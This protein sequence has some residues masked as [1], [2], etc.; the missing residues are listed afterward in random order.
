MIRRSLYMCFL[1][2]GLLLACG[3]SFAAAPPAASTGKV[4]IHPFTV[5]GNQRLQ[6][7]G[8]QIADRVGNELKTAGMTVSV[9]AAPGKSV[10]N[11]RNTLLAT[12]ARAAVWGTLALQGDGFTLHARVLETDGREH[13]LEEAEDSI[14]L[15]FGSVQKLS[16]RIGEL[17][18]GRDT[19]GKVEI[20][21]NN[22]IEDDAISR[23][24]QTAP[25]AVYLQ[26]SLSDDL[27]SIY[28]MG[29][30]EDIQVAEEDG[31]GGKTVIFT[32]EEKPT[33]RQIF[34][35]G[36]R[37]YE[38]EKVLEVVTTKT[39]AILNVF[40]VKR[41]I[42]RIRDLYREKNYH[43]TEVT[44]EINPLDNNQ[45]D[46][47]FVI[48]EGEKVK[49]AEILFE[50]NE[51]YSEKELKK[52]IETSEKGWFS[53]LTGSGELKKEA[54]QQDAA[55]MTAFYHN[56]GFAEA[57]VG[58]PEITFDGSSATVKFKISEGPRFKIGEVGVGGDLIL[59]E[60]TLLGVT[61]IGKQE[62]Y[63]RDVVQKDIASLSDIYADT[64]YANAD[65][66]PQLKKNLENGTLDIQYTI[67][68]GPQVYVNRIDISGNTKTRDKVIRRQLPIVEQELYS[69]RKLKRGVRNLN[70]L[71]YF[72]D[73]RVE[74]EKTDAD[75][76]VNLKVT[77][78]E[79]PTGMFTFGAGYS[80][81]DDLFGQVSVT[82][83]NFLGKGQTLN[84][85]ADVGS[86]STK[87]TLSFSEP[88]L[89]D[90]P[91][92]AGF[93]LYNWDKDYDE[94]EKT[95]TGGNVRFGYPVWDY[96]RAYISYGYEKFD[97]DI[98][99]PRNVNDDI[100]AMEPLDTSSNV[101]LS[102]KYDSRNR[103][104]NASEGSSHNLTIKH[105]G[106]PLGGD[107]AFTKYTAETGWYFP[108]FWG[109]V[110]F[111]HAEGGYVQENSE[112]L[113]PDYEKFYLGGINSVR[114]YEWRDIA[115][116]YENELGYLV[117]KGGDKFGQVNL[118]VIFPLIKDAGLMGLGFVD[119][120][121]VYDTDMNMDWD[122][123]KRSVGYG[124]RWF[125]PIGPI[126]LEYGIPLDEIN[127]EK[128]DGR[129]EF[130]MGGA[131]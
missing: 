18:V 42:E 109:S 93:D 3:L 85:K 62:W 69:S 113:L 35:R 40:Q 28:D 17:L 112:G 39:G 114:G 70:R 21:G 9:A 84:L 29:Y 52:Q 77:V 92:S 4:R 81:Q 119:A 117:D 53:W 20:R 1:V 75:D 66:Y 101:S 111:A 124:I 87:Y 43:H 64:G 80:S 37:V 57:R 49:V 63:N 106:G 56:S 104:F 108:L 30:F 97:I 103:M 2:A 105:A 120:G 31:E 130:T 13:T 83:R 86:S 16:R 50:G 46:L 12:D 6:Y 98:E 10:A 131:F 89:F 78:A 47:I 96:T 25:G 65:I 94:Y 73:V 19:V 116:Y 15:L 122:G 51:A 99:D 125:S 5:E 67:Q 68:Q 41:D 38:K 32:V 36:N 59:S 129:W 79:K 34:V 126:R 107:I 95:S 115:I 100:L 48:A 118:E 58:D 44:Y 123:V 8:P 61:G 45:A 72:E 23:V 110:F 74:T 24:I 76:K 60:E 91:L 82:Q 22:R 14:E 27:K 33:V 7:L 54:A 102:L 11:V 128:Q 71:E 55:R 127:N 121:N 26:K 90:K 88:Y